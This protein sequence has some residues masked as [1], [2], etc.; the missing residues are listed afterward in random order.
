MERSIRARARRTSR[1]SSITNASDAKS[2]IP[3]PERQRLY[4][5]TGFEI[6]AQAPVTLHPCQPYYTGDVL[7]LFKRLK[8]AR[9]A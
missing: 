5:R 9:A 6:F 1:G 7:L 4:R 8:Q 3:S 2:G